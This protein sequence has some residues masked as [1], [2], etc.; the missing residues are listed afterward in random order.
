[1]LYWHSILQNVFHF[2]PDMKQQYLYTEATSCNN[3]SNRST[4]T[5]IWDNYTISNSKKFLK[6]KKT[7][8]KDK[9]V[10]ITYFADP[11]HFIDIFVLYKTDLKIQS[12]FI[13]LLRVCINSNLYL[14]K[15][16][17]KN[18]KDVFVYLCSYCICV[19]VCVCGVGGVLSPH[20]SG[21]GKW[22]Y[23][24]TSLSWLLLHITDIRRSLHFGPRQ[25]W[26]CGDHVR[27]FSGALGFIGCVS[28]ISDKYTHFSK[29]AE[30]A[31]SLCRFYPVPFSG[32]YNNHS[33]EISIQVF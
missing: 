27:N 32:Q 21:S 2:R 25:L 17:F 19:F 20:F 11:V 1:M 30:N 15:Y 33:I 28:Y 18:N 26:G 5:N 7:K 9:F 8:K 24:H 13:K 23:Y 3:Q 6:W 10:K 31:S 14:Q 16:T 4:I 22:L 12:V 29:V